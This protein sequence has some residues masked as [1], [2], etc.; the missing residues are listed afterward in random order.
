MKIDNKQL[1]PVFKQWLELGTNKQYV[2]SVGYNSIAHSTFLAYLLEELGL[3]DAEVKK[4]CVE[5]FKTEGIGLMNISQF[6][7]NLAKADASLPLRK[8]RTLAIELA[9]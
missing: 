5:L 3:I 7:Q 2:A 1:V 8:A 6:T 9:S 4:E